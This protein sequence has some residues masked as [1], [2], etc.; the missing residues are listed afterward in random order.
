MA[1]VTGIVK[2]A[3]NGTI[4]RS[5][6]NAELDF[7]GM[8]RQAAVG[9]KLYGHSEE[10]VPS[11]LKFTIFH[12]SDTDLLALKDIKNATARFECDTGPIYPITNATVVNTLK[13]KGGDGKVDV[14]MEGDP[15]D[16]KQ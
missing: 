2:I 15:V 9:Y 16:T 8:K 11:H 7:G 10:L 3:V 5:E 13:L 6:I 14:E 4:Q 1:D 12:L